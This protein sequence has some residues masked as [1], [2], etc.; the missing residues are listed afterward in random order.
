MDKEQVLLQTEQLLKA[1][2]LDGKLAKYVYEGLFD[3]NKL[4]DSELNIYKDKINLVLN[5]IS[6]QYAVGYVNFYGYNFIVNN[7]VLIPH[8]ETEELV[9]YTLEYIKKYFNNNISIL[10]IGTGSGIIAITLKK[11]LPLANIY[12][13]DISLE[14]LEVAKENAKLL[15]AKINFVYGD[16]LEPVKD[17]KFD[18][19]IANLPYIREDEQIDKIVY[20][21]EPHIALFGGEDGLNHYRKLFKDILLVLKNKALIAL[22]I[23]EGQIQETEK[24]LA[25]YLKDKPYIFKKDMSGRTRMLFIFNNID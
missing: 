18:L 9:Y 19:I 11:E 12:A 10:D 22:E 15:D 20:D 3:K 5:G 6:P 1:N 16:L 7:N 24:L 2:E 21:N 14:A 25:K 4:D 8:F 13:S 17:K 23:A